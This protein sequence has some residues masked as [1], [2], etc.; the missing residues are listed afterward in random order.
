[1]S[2][3]LA[4]LESDMDE[5]HMKGWPKDGRGLSQRLRRSSNF[6][7]RVGIDISFKRNKK[8]RVV[9]VSEIE[10]EGDA[11]GDAKSK[12]DEKCE[13]ENKCASSPKAP[14]HGENDAGD[15][16]DGVVTNNSLL[17][18]YIPL[19]GEKREQQQET[20]RKGSQKSVTSVLAS[21]KCNY[22]NQ[23]RKVSPEVCEWHLEENDPFCLKCKEG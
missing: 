13:G 1:M 19:R 17:T 22:N 23:P 18:A 2:A 8:G 10:E 15:A 21:S 4:E 5:N 11:K 9:M 7:R 14:N 3:L 16:N 12:G 6:L 20:D